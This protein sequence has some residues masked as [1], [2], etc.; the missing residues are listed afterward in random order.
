MGSFPVKCIFINRIRMNGY[1][2]IAV[3]FA[4][5]TF[6]TCGSK[7]VDEDHQNDNNPVKDK[8]GL[9]HWEKSRKELL[10][11]SDMVLL[12]GGGKHRTHTWEQE[13][14]NPYVS[15]TDEQGK[16]HWLFDSFL[17][18]EIHNGEGKMFAS[19][20]TS[21]PAN[22]QDWKKLVDYYFQ[23]R[24]A[25]GALNRAVEAASSRIGEPRTK[26]KVVIGLPEPIRNQ[27]DWGSVSDGK[28]LDFSLDSDRIKACKWY[29]DHVR[30]R[31]NEMNYKHIELAGFYWIAEEA[32]NTRTIVNEISGYLNEL[33]YT[34]N[35]IPYFKSDGYSEWKRLG[36]NYAYLQPNYF[37][38][39]TIA[40]DRLN[41]ACKIALDYDM[42]M[43][44]EFDERVSSGWGYRL[45]D[46]MKA[47]K[48]NGIW[49]SKRLAYYQGNKALHMLSKSEKE[50]DKV[51]Y[52]EFCKFV[53]DRSR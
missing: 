42:D 38:N 22:Q 43:E 19:G 4:T 14:T 24:I 21:T 50:N 1:K 23:S 18:L 12:Y 6:F 5:L 52:H 10:D 32:T 41:N 30:A 27:K 25:L 17:F 3:I 15:Y 2:I 9:Y 49:S 33:K 34:F 37:F 44:I 36:F 8:D 28:M 53:V 35:W 26:R 20:Y 40:Y 46:Y 29:I 51:L 11:Y 39:E 16:E 45:K 47:F 31:F 48:E 7:I 13:Y